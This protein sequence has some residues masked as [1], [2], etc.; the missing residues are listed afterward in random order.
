MNAADR[1]SGEEVV[2]GVVMPA[3]GILS[4]LLSGL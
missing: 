3:R 4:P 2:L 1:G